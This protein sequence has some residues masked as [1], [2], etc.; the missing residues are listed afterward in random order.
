MQVGTEFAAIIAVTKTIH[1]M[2]RLLFSLMFAAIALLPTACN[3][4]PLPNTPDLSGN[5][6][7]TWVLDTKTVDNVTTQDGKTTSDSSSTDF[8]GDNFM[9]RLTDF[10]VAFA[11]EGSVLTFDIDDVDEAKYSYNSD[12]H[13]ISFEKALVLSKGFLNAKVMNLFGK[14]DVLELSGSKL[15]LK[16]EETTTLGSYSTTTTTVYSYHRLVEK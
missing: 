5:L 3:P 10:L 9:L 1:I 11:Q 8:T 15:V 7:G 4:E 6:Y 2:K 13:Q 14:Y 12:L 16:K